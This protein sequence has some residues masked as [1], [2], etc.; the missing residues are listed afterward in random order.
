SR[1]R[2][3]PPRPDRLPVPTKSV[4]SSRM[5]GEHVGW[6]FGDVFEVVA[7]AVPDRP[8]QIHG[9]V[10]RTWREFDRR[11][12]ALAHDLRDAGLGQQSKV[13]CYLY[14]GPEYFEVVQGSFKGAFVPFNTN[15]RYGPEEVAY[16]FDNADA[17]AVVFH[18][19]FAELL[20]S[21]RGQLPLV[22]RWYAVDDGPGI[23]PWAVSYEAL[24]GDGADRMVPPWGRSGDD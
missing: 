9:D 2:T 20:D 17:E 6:N 7:E 14:N 12:N 11:A 21:I 1:S 19:S 10:V 23:P 4:S 18:S 8:A 13:A 5:G 16:L 3:A 15:Y 22:K 24:V